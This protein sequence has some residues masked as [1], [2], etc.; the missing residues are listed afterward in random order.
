MEVIAFVGPPGSGK[1]HRASLVADQYGCD[2][3][4]DD[5]LII[6]EGKILA[7]S[8]AKRADTRVGAVKRAIFLD[9]AHR[10]EALAAVRRARPRRILILGTSEDMIVR[11][12]DA[13]DLP[14]PETVV[15][16][17]DVA[18]PAQ[19]RL[20]RRKRRLE[21]KHV[22][23]AP[24]F[25]VKKTFSGYMV[26]PLRFLLRRREGDPVPVEKSVVR[27][28][29]SSLG[30][31]YIAD[32]VLSAIAARAAEAVPGIARVLRAVV[33]SGEEGVQVELDVALRFGFPVWAPLRQAQEAVKAQLEY[34][35]A[36]NVV[37]VNVHARR[38]QVD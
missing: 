11:I 14:R 29:F 2:L 10:A 22:V 34:M 24:T 28:T 8:S 36:L 12:T 30:H 7:G 20:A 1:S 32:T 18:S 3:I 26:D 33:E 17:E 13:L 25:E 6:Q 19:I 16:I 37:S 21:G 4:I 23:P 15:R 35:T 27:P 31:F 5:G 38:V 9:P